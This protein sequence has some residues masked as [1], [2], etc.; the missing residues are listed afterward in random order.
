MHQGLSTYNL[1]TISVIMSLKHGVSAGGV[2]LCI[3][4]LVSV[5]DLLQ[6]R[7]VVLTLQGVTN[8]CRAVLKTAPWRFVR[9]Y[10]NLIFYLA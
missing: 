2:S 7:D 4:A 8:S 9:E 5:Q 10:P 6:C 3:E 1:I